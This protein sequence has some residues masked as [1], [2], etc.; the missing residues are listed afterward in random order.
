MNNKTFIVL[1]IILAVA[2]GAGIKASR[3]SGTTKGDTVK[4]SNFPMT[5]GEWQGTDIPLKERDYQIL[6]TRNLIMRDYK[7]PQGESVYLYIIYSE[8]NRKTLHPPEIC[9]TGGGTSTITEKSVIPIT[10]STKAN[11]FSIDYKNYSE[12]V[13]YWFKSAALSTPSYPR[14]QL[15][16]VLSRIFGKNASGSAM[17]RIS[18]VIKDKNQK[19]ALGLVKEFAGEMEP[20]LSK[21]VP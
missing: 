17:I 8:G 19:A 11:E 3:Q 5:I 20:L 7:N 18:T 1:F 16:F 15:A 10:A 13:V 2:V 9:Y 21:Y 14:Q 12:L 6:E 4:M